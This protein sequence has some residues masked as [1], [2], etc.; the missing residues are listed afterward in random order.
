[1]EPVKT[2]TMK[3][4]EQVCEQH[5]ITH[6]KPNKM[7]EDLLSVC[8]QKCIPINLGFLA[9]LQ[10]EGYI[11]LNLEWNMNSRISTTISWGNPKELI[12]GIQWLSQEGTKEV[13][14]YQSSCLLG[15]MF[16]DNARINMESNNW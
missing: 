4:E 10:S 12:I 1:V 13:F 3:T 8:Q 2:A 15:Y 9:S 11:Y 16:H 6:R 14:V 5:V 7:M